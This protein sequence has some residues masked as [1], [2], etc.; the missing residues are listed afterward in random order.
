MKEGNKR[1]A[2]HRWTTAAVESF[3]ICVTVIDFCCHL[4]CAD[5]TKVL[6]RGAK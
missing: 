4:V 3:G 1:Q 5:Y 2:R 6:P